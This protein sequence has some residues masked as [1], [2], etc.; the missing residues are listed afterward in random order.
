MTKLRKTMLGLC[1]LSFF[2]LNVNLVFGV[3]GVCDNSH[4]NGCQSGILNPNAYADNATHYRWGCSQ[5]RGGT[6]SGV[7]SFPKPVP[8]NGVCGNAQNNC[9]AGNFVDVDDTDTHYRWRCDG[10][11][12][13]SGVACSR[14][15]GA[16]VEN[17]S[18]VIRDIDFSFNNVLNESDILDEAIVS[19]N[20][21]TSGWIGILFYV[22]IGISIF[23]T[24]ERKKIRRL[25]L[26]LYTLMFLTMVGIIMIIWGIL[27]DVEEFIKVIV[28]Y[29]CIAI[30]CLIKKKS[31][32]PPS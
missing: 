5:F 19:V 10:I 22:I 27:E 9:Q 8:V 18:N 26:S 28:L 29:Y 1:I 17:I 16:T 24:F 25:N 31:E 2:F 6:N 4:R 3:D 15:I 23:V 12:G 7:C 20:E 32:R 13:G 11:N 14:L 21:E 30:F